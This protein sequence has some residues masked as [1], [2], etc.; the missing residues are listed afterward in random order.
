MWIYKGVWW[1][2]KEFLSEE[3]V[4]ILCNSGIKIVS[5]LILLFDDYVF[6]EVFIGKLLE[7]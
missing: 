4:E 3:S 2:V 5:E 6:V 1:R 7:M